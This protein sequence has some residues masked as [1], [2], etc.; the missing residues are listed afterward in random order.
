MNNTQDDDSTQQ[1]NTSAPLREVNKNG[2]QNEQN[3]PDYR[4]S[5]SKLERT[6]VSDGQQLPVFE[7]HH[8]VD[9]DV[10]QA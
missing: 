5:P 3:A 2:E 9:S 1:F 7:S 4:R 10:S 6:T 8:P